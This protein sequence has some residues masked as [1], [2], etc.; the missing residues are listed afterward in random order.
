[1]RWTL[2]T[3]DWDAF[4]P[5]R[6]DAGLLRAVKAAA[7]VEFNAP[8]Y[9]TY[10]CNVFSDRP[11]MRADFEQWGRE[12]EQHG[13]ALSK[14]ARLADPDFDFDTAF[15]RFRKMQNIDTEAI[16]S[17]RGSRAGEMVARCVVETGT[18]SFYTA[19]KDHTDEPCLKQV[20]TYMAADEFAHYRLFYETFR[21]IEK[22][23]PISP[24]NQ[25]HVAVS[26]LNEADDHELAG[27][28]YCAN[29]DKG[30]N[31]EYDM[32]RFANEY[33]L[34]AMSV[35][36]QQHISR[37]VSMILK[38]GGRKPHGWLAERVCRVVWWGWSRKLER[39]RATAAH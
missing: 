33:F 37:V 7:L 16:E 31:V 35:Y 25:L 18:S 5:S 34:E 28:F 10:L 22:T 8:D 36:R 3:I 13:K 19:I 29:Y 4:D 39:L 11:E 2:D 1:M 38:A 9:V 21:D 14:W 32:H 6:V 26:R 23:E 12:E 15:D 30:S 20:V 27:A 24:A 17:L